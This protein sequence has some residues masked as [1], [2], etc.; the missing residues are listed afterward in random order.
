MSK[1]VTATGRAHRYGR[2][3]RKSHAVKRPKAKPLPLHLQ[4]HP[5]ALHHTTH[6]P[7][8]ATYKEPTGSLIANSPFQTM[9]FTVGHLLTVHKDRVRV[10]VEGHGTWYAHDSAYAFQW[11]RGARS[12]GLTVNVY[13]EE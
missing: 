12:T 11:A 7:D 3:T 5:Q 9:L 1:Y 2:T 13:I 8:C 10:V 4:C 6:N